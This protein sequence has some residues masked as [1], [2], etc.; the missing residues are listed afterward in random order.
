MK[1]VLCFV[2]DNCHDLQKTLHAMQAD[3]RKLED[4]TKTN[5]GGED[6][7][8][9]ETR[10]A[11]MSSPIILRKAKKKPK[12]TGLCFNDIM[13]TRPTAGRIRI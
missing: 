2:F 12:I 11:C 4:L 3:E 13:N 7:I 5:R 8:A 10:Y 9:D 1:H 6:H